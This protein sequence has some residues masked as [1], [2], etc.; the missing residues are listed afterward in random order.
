MLTMDHDTMLLSSFNVIPTD[1]VESV[2]TGLNEILAVQTNK[3]IKE[4]EFNGCE[5]IVV[6]FVDETSFAI[7]DEMIMFDLLSLV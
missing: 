2:R 6:R 5:D 3:Q 4:F 1:E 7:C